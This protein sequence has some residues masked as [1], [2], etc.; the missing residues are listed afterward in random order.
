MTTHSSIFA[1]RIPRTEEPGGLQFMGSQRSDTT[2]VAAHTYLEHFPGGTSGK[3][4]T[5]QCRRRRRLS[6]HGFS[7]WVG[8]I[9][10]RRA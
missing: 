1:W 6:R 5:C 7:S 10:W 2:E 8:K 9:P 4:S 3:E